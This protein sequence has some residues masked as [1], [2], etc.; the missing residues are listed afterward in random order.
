M[1]LDAIAK[2]I[3]QARAEKLITLA[4]T[5]PL[6]ELAEK[7]LGPTKLDKRAEDLI[8]DA[9]DVAEAFA[10]EKGVPFTGLL[11]E[12]AEKVARAVVQAIA[13]PAHVSVKGGPNAPI[14]TTFEGAIPPSPKS[15][16]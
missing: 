12:L 4:A 6:R 9:V 5:G 11:A 16:T 13:G 10:G 15:P 1:S 8:G 2:F 14:T 3:E 7:T